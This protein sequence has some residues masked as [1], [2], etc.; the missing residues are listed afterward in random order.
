V[1]GVYFTGAAA[2]LHLMGTTA[3]GSPNGTAAKC[4][5]MDRAQKPPAL[6]LP[7]LGD[8]QTPAERSCRNAN[9]TICAPWAPGNPRCDTKNTRSMLSLDFPVA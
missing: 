9:G 7:P 8:T 4:A 3:V 2:S 1:A 6:H 5:A